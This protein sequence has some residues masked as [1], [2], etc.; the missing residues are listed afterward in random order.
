MSKLFWICVVV[1]TY[2]VVLALRVTP[3]R[4]Y[5]EYYNS[6]YIRYMN[7][8][9]RRLSRHSPYTFNVDFDALY[10]FG[11][12]V[13]LKIEVYEEVSGRYIPIP[14]VVEKKLCDFLQNDQL[15]GQKWFKE[16]SSDQICPFKSGEHKFRNINVN[17]DDFPFEIPFTW[18]SFMAKI[19]V[20][21]TAFLTEQAD[22]R[23]SIW[24]QFYNI[25]R[26]PK[27][28]TKSG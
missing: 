11:N 2:G 3:E 22:V 16:I 8:S 19:R 21:I 26:K 25:V 14:I 28:Q 5:V 9:V 20:D 13:T 7:V 12:N 18:S 23:L 15:F 6:D 1:C 17:L 27:G 10:Y 4:F 24:K